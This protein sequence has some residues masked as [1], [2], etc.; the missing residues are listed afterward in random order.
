MLAWAQDLKAG[1]NS[2]AR[3][4]LRKN[5]YIYILFISVIFFYTISKPTPILVITCRTLNSV[6][7]E[8]EP[9]SWLET[10]VLSKMCLPPAS[11]LVCCCC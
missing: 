6:A 7:T 5:E 4:H 2:I 11:P 1:V 10:Q 9:V 8:K 3:L